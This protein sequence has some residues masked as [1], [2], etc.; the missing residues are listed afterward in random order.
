MIS[1]DRDLWLVPWCALPTSDGKMIL[2]EL[3]IE[4]VS[5]IRHSNPTTRTS[6]ES[7]GAFVLADVDFDS[8]GASHT[9]HRSNGVVLAND[10]RSVVP[11][12]RA[13][14][15]PGTKAEAEAISP[16]VEEIAGGPPT[17]ATRG[18]A[19]ESR[20]K[21]LANPRLAVFATH[22]F[23]T[24]AESDGG[25][26]I[27]PLLRCGLCLAGFNQHSSGESDDGVLSGLEVAGLQLNGTE[28]V[29]L[30]ACESGL[31]D[32]RSIDGVVGLRQAFQAAGAASVVS[33]LWSVP[34]HDTAFLMESFFDHFSQGKPISES[35]RQAQLKRIEE[36]R[37][38]TSA[39]H[40]YYWAAFNVTRHISI[41]RDIED[42]QKPV[43][44]AQ[45]VERTEEPEP[46]SQ[47]RAT[48]I[49]DRADIM[50]GPQKV[51]TVPKGVVLDVQE[52]RQH[53]GVWWLKVRVPN[54][55]KTG[56][57]QQTSVRN[58]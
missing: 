22:G 55:N 44:S 48:V 15:L 25:S 27:N 30:S 43:T 18:E 29:V 32:V 6:H 54:S 50:N 57:I 3:P 38:D 2:E 12:E 28:L 51:A 46:I 47:S 34:D 37:Q 24:A 26:F 42:Q 53:S 1:P 7:T 41:P 23:F 13:R 45:T 11:F 8:A 58:E 19:T 4:F 21:Q 39:A 36:H 31:G 35:L 49:I 20:V 52:R 16:F 9:P 56:W 5:T 14:P 33:T 10:Q 17:I 40:P